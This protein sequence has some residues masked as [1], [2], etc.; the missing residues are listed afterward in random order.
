MN[1]LL[2]VIFISWVNKC[3][4][5]PKLQDCLANTQTMSS[6]SWSW[7][8]RTNKLASYTTLPAKW[9]IPKEMS[10]LGSG[11][12]KLLKKKYRWFILWLVMASDK[13]VST[14]YFSYFSKKTCCRYLLGASNE[15]HKM[16]SW[17]Y[18]TN[19]STFCLKKNNNILTSAITLTKYL[20]HTVRTYRSYYTNVC[21]FVL[22]FYGPVNPMGSCRAWSVY[23]TTRLLGRLSPLSG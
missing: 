19:I 3:E 16:F 15:F 2:L 14:L 20:N 1:N 18:R 10:S 23:L 6:D 8:L 13:K 9:R 5:N 22:R 4:T 17:R 11:S 7:L 21:L 12:K